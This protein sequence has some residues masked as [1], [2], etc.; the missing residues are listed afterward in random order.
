VDGD[1]A[2]LRAGLL[3]LADVEAGSDPQP[4][5]P[6]PIDDLRCAPDRPCRLVERGEETVTRRVDLAAAVP[7]QQ[8]PDE[9]VMHDQDLSPLP[10]PHFGG[11][12]G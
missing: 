1:S 6:Q 10:I 7:P 11:K 12:F 5:R 3:H 8:T 4:A 9:R 2:N